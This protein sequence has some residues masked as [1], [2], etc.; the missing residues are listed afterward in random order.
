MSKLII[1]ESKDSKGK[2]EIYHVFFEN[3]IL[4]YLN[5]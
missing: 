5:K 4:K 1:S 3:C 2:L